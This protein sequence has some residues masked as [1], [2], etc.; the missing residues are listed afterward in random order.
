MYYFLLRVHTH[1]GAFCISEPGIVFSKNSIISLV[2]YCM[3]IVSPQSLG[4]LL[5]CTHIEKALGACY[6]AHSYRE[7][8]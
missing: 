3:G 5:L 1:V 7:I 6:C 4:C 8:R 2:H